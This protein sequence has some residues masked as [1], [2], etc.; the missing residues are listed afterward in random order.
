MEP[1]YLI[2]PWILSVVLLSLLLLWL[3]TFILHQQLISRLRSRHHVL[4][5]EL[6]CPST[7]SQAFGSTMPIFG[8][9]SFRGLGPGAPSMNYV[10]WI[11]IKGYLMIK[12]DRVAALGHGLQSLRVIGGV[13]ALVIV[14]ATV[15]RIQGYL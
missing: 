7:W 12:D 13:W 2:A 6:G 14:V 5:L 3:G 15:A 11:A 10:G 9:S 1:R 8:G 4:W